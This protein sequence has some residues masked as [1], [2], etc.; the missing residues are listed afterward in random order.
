MSRYTG[1]RLRIIRRFG[2]LDLPGLTRKR[3]KN[4]NPQVCMGR[5]ARKSLNTPSA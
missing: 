5:S 2:G 4:T 3:P 1:P